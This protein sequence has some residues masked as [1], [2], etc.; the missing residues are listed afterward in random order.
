MPAIL[1]LRTGF[2]V[3]L[4]LVTACV[5]G[6]FQ[7]A[8]FRDTK[9]LYQATMREYQRRHWDNAVAGFE[10]LSVEL[11]AQDSL[12]SRVLYYLGRAHEG[13]KEWL[14]A[15][16]TFNRLTESFPDDTLADDALL[17]AGNDYA[18]MWRSPTLDAEY[19]ETAINTFNTLL[20]VYPNSP[21]RADAERGIAR[22]QQWFATKNYENAMH[23]FRRK[24][25]DSAIIY[26]KD[27]VRLYPEAPRA[28]DALLRLVEAY[29]HNSYR[30]DASETC[31]ALH[32]KYPRD[33]EVRELCG[34]APRAAAARAP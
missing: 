9:T 15:A 23:Y 1:R 34:E 26:L 24:A 13:K 21:L 14:L 11:P 10:R 27:I 19:G 22:L 4:A 16:Q 29:R 28:R 7:A 32:G 8:R 33:R 20:T 12:L 5:S 30:E 17:A 6:G 2:F 3:T 31:G 18:R 25:Y